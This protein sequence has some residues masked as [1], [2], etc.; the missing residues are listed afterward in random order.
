MTKRII[1]L[2]L[3]SVLLAGSTGC[4]L[5]RGLLWRPL[6]SGTMCNTEHCVTG[7]GSMRGAECGPPGPAA[8]A[9]D[10]DPTCG[11]VRETPCAAPRGPMHGRGRCGRRGPLSL[12]VG[13]LHGP[14]WCGP[15]CG[16]IYWGDFHGDPPDGCDP[17]DRC[18]N[19]TGVHVKGCVSGCGGG[20]YG[21]GPPSAYAP[22][23]ASKVIGVEPAPR[24]AQPQ[25]A[26]PR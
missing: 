5:L 17:C 21:G 3:A 9:G 22:A 10:C 15:G 6:G 7:Y 12:V 2:G 16:E 8:C 14:S 18:G 26:A 20:C 19:F 13:L 1:L 25:K 23:V 4:G 24:V 11:P